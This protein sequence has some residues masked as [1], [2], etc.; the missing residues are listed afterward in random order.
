ML[1]AMG[2]LCLALCGWCCGAAAAQR[3]SLHRQTLEQTLQLLERI[4]QEIRYRKLPLDAVLA[5]LRREGA[6]PLLGLPAC[7][8]LQRLPAPEVLTPA[9][10]ACFR[11]CFS[12]L[13]HGS[14]AQECRRLACYRDRFGRMQAEAREQER[15]ARQLYPRLG[16]AAGAMLAIAVL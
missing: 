13:G 12:G 2:A 1:R 3:A 10:Q 7:A 15:Q 14:G 5:A 11:E 8:G 16:L 4:T 9:E 6:C